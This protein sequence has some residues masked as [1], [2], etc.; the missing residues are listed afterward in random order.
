MRSLSTTEAVQKMKVSD[1][2]GA[3]KDLSFSDPVETN[4]CKCAQ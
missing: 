4:L 3:I 1:Y 2:Q